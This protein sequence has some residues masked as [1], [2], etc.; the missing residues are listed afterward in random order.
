[1]AVEEEEDGKAVEEKEKESG[2]DRLGYC[3]AR[4]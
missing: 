1:M 2:M 3:G 4:G